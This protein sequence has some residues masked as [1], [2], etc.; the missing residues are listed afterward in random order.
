MSDTPTSVPAR[1]PGGESRLRLVRGEGAYT[2][3]LLSPR[4]LH[5]VFLRADRAHAR[6]LRVDLDAAR[7]APGVVAAWAAGDVGPFGTFP[8]NLRYTGRDGAPLRAPGRPPIAS[9]K[10]RHVGEIVAMVVARDRISAESA[11]ELIAVDYADL[12]AIVGI[13]AALAPDAPAIHADVPGNLAIEVE[14]GDAP[15]CRAA[16]ARAAH[17]VSL[18]V[19][20]PRLVPNA[21][22]PRSALAIYDGKSRR[23]R[24]HAPH[25]GAPELRRDLS[26]V[27]DIPEDR[28]DI[29]AE[30][31]GGAF[32]ARGP[33][34][35]EHALLLAAARRLRRPVRWQGS[36][37][38]GFASDHH[39]RGTRL[40]GTLALDAR[41]R[42]LA[43][44]MLYE[45]DLGAWITPV[46]AHINVHNP[47]QTLTGCYRIPVAHG[48]FRLAFTNAVPIGPY[49]GAGRPDI[50]FL[51]ERLV[52]E[53]ARVSGI[54][55]VALRRRNLVPASAFPHVTPVGVRYDSGDYAR[56]LDEALDLSD[57]Q[58][59]RSRSRDAARQGL[60]HGIGLALFV[61][62]AGGGPVTHDS[63]RLRRDMA[64]DGPL[65]II[66]TLAQSTGQSQAEALIA[67]AAQALAVPAHRIGLRP[68]AQGLAGAGAFASRTTSTVGAALLAAC[69]AMRARLEGGEDGALV[70]QGSALPSLSFPSGCH[71]AEVL[72]D[73]AT[74]V[75]RLTRYT[76]VD[77]VGR[78][79]SPAAIEGQIHGGI[80]QGIGGAL[81]EAARYDSDGQLLTSTLMDYALPRADDLTHYATRLVEIPSPNNPLGVKGVGE[82]G[83]TGALA[84]LGNAVNHALAR[85]G[86][87]PIDIP[88]TPAAIWQALRD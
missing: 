12:P 17:V 71:V 68:V 28:I 59:A 61:E 9:D 79:L 72:V 19:E 70:T 47:L 78:A 62:V 14:A 5:A 74:G 64:P 8:A 41:G 27:L 87:G 11:A 53:A 43:L 56:L 51:V 69:Q 48:A 21:M 32:G 42:F 83:T 4:E 52:D 84:A 50:A 45:A 2:A 37:L 40:T 54:D 57:W 13:D 36:R 24:L 82:A 76:A 75:V 10:V 1:V 46:G 23:Y 66:E 80:A 63:V 81:M 85:R 49:R 58:G 16:R 6:I 20:L 18:T 15:G 38:E 26:R 35:P 65:Y 29:I 86:R 7:A 3:D 44:D 55:R 67:I 60:L 30:H 31:V 34:Y 77:D 25:Q 22:E 33:A 73:P 88:F 39:G